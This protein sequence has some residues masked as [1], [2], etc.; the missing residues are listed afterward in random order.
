MNKKD[1]KKMLISLSDSIEKFHA[2]NIYVPSRTVYF[3]AST[4]GLE[5]TDDV[6]AYTVAQAIKNLHI[7]DS[8]AHDEITL[9]LNTPGGTWDD[10]MAMYDV[11][12]KLKS[13]VIILGIGKIYSMGSIIMQAGRERYLMENASMMIHDGSDGYCGNSKSFEAWAE[14]SKKIRYTMYHIYYEKMKKCNSKITIK[15][16]EEMCSHD[17]IFGAKEAVEIGLADEIIRTKK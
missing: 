14:Y 5:D 16:I 7:L 9:L 10:G 8:L 6:N 15:E 12:N 17:R 2:D 13:D 3:G 11:I 4:A 1:T